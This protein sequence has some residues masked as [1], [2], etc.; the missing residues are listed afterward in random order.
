[1]Y[2]GTSY[3]FYLIQGHWKASDYPGKK[4]QPQGLLSVEVKDQ[5]KSMETVDRPTKQ[6]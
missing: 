5:V 1:M 3:C 4:S 6:G 2:P